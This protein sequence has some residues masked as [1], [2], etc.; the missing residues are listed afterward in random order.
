MNDEWIDHEADEPVQQGD[1][2]LSRDPKT[3][4]IKDLCTVITADCD[5]AH[6]KF[7]EQL[8]CLRV[9]SLQDYMR[10][11]W[12]ERKLR[13]NFDT[14]AERIR[15]QLD[16]WNSQRDSN[17]GPLSSE[18]VINWVKGCEP[19]QIC[20]DLKIPEPVAAK[21]RTTLARFRSAVLAL[22]ADEATDNLARLVCFRA[23]MSG[24][25][26]D[27]CRNDI[28][29]QAQNDRLPDDVFLLTSLPQLPD[30][31]PAMVLLR[32]LIGIPSGTICFR[33][34]D[35]TSK[36]HFLRIGRLNPVI[37]YAVSQAFGVLYTRI[38][39]PETYES[40]RRA[41]I[42]QIASFQWE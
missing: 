34:Y 36:D 21:V 30:V 11:D 17:A 29:R 16:K 9:V 38:G 41:A 24:Q 15:A 22:V 25:P 37:K 32:E 19:D 31:G 14:E 13:R 26:R 2:L 4:R 6:Q 27:D 42:E 8:A 7:G 39:L 40:R 20:Q 10:A 3:G 33:S 35:A 18:V 5:I 28:L 12:A 1:L 23:A